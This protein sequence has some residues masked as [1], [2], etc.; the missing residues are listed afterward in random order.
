[1]KLFS[2]K[3]ARN[4]LIKV[5]IIIIIV[6]AITFY[7]G[8][9][10]ISYFKNIEES[11]AIIQSFG[12]FAPLIMIG[13][14]IIIVL[15]A[16]VSQIPL[17]VGSGFAFGAIP[18]FCYALVGFFIGGTIA[19]FLA[20]KFGRPFVKKIITKNAM[21]KL[22]N[23]SGARLNTILFFFFLV[24]IF[25]DAMCYVAG[26]TNIKYK[27]FVLISV[28]G[29]LP[30][31]LLFAFA[32]NSLASMHYVIGIILFG[33]ILVCGA[34]ILIFQKRIENHVVSRFEKK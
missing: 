13:L 9:L 31:V 3:E 23:Y 11:K 7:L 26:L 2:S 5:A 21:E 27:T 22:D 18:A 14:I 19:F 30:A 25:P 17:I 29:R 20:R 8:S 24:P 16:F 10:L 1:M 34:I 33:V 12:A 6:L 28:L 4:K 15:L 32:G